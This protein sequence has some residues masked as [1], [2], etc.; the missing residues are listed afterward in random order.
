MSE[1]LGR[2]GRWLPATVAAAFSGLL[3]VLFL[4][5]SVDAYILPRTVL[6]LAVGLAGLGLLW[7][8]G[9]LR[10]AALAV[11]AAAVL[12]WAF[13]VL[14]SLSFTGSY[15]RYESLPVRLAYLGLFG[16]GA[17][18]GRES[19]W[20]SLAF[21][22]GCCVAAFEAVVQ[23]LTGSLPRPD[24][25]LGQS[26]LLGALLAMAFVLA[27][28]RAPRGPLWAAAGVLL[29]LGLAASSSRSGWVAALVGLVV[30]V[31]WAVPG[32]RVRLAGLAGAA[33]VGLALLFV[34]ASP[35]RNLNS[36]T[37]GA[38]LGVWGD[39]FRMGAARPFSGWG[40]EGM[41]L[42]FGRY[43][44]RDW[45]PGDSFDRAHDEPLDLLVTQGGLG[46]AACAAFFAV[47]WLGLWR[48][49]SP[50]LAG[51][52][53]ACAGYGAWSLL[54]FDWAPATGAF[55]LLAGLA[56]GTGLQARAVAVWEA[57]LGLL[58]A[59]F[60][61]ALGVTAQLAD[62]A[63]FQGFPARAVALDPRQPRYHA[64]LGGLGDLRRAAAL[65]D[66]DVSTYVRLGDALAAAG[67]RA[68]A[69]AAYRRAL[70]IY[71]FD[72]TARGRLATAGP[73]G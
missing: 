46:L 25:N 70:E 24:G 27:A 43:Q 6:V 67:D 12:A 14:P 28:V 50:A 68:G 34:L 69:V 32:R 17:A 49:R 60:G 59:G 31:V 66:V 16:W 26:N 23:W 15:S 18:A 19:R 54:N 64:A 30:A 8:L 61:L 36:D 21:V 53:G 33:L 13:S 9:P 37:G 65:G 38:R 63:Y 40:E 71:P 72:P 7:R 42:Y 62:V 35:L 22:A 41:G 2:A 52:A 44:S 39:A 1:L 29:G 4:P 45:E 48:R 57:V 20:V 3:P 56:W 58:G 55:W 47:F 51:L 10:W 5:T 11:A 73:A